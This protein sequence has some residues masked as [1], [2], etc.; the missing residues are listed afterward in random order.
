MGDYTKNG[1][2]I[3][4]CGKAYYATLQM[5]QNEKSIG[6]SE[7]NH[8]LKP[9]NK[10]SFAFPFPEYDG[11]KIG[12]ISNFHEGDRVDF[13]IRIKKD[14]SNTFHQKI[15]HHIHPKGVAGINLFCDCPYHSSENVSKNFVGDEIVFNLKEQIYFQG[16]LH[17]SGECVY[18]GETNV[19]DESEAIEV[20]E[21]LKKE[22]EQNLLL[23]KREEYKNTSN[24]DFH[25]KKAVYLMEVANRILATYIR[26]PQTV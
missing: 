7:I 6:D 23:S 13:Q 20:C 12:E 26:E 17:I 1:Q 5:L 16:N 4:T 24:K 25:E 10:C 3:G 19:F 18:C 11:K 2:K 14:G 21:N 8:Y 15:V 22:S 9:E